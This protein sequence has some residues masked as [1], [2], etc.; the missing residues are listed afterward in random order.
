[1]LS[2]CIKDGSLEAK[3]VSLGRGARL[4]YTLPPN[5]LFEA[6]FKEKQLY[7]DVIEVSALT[8]A[9][10]NFDIFCILGLK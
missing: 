7:V 8:V 10:A 9:I 2:N 5:S 4:E 6:F 1:M 3:D